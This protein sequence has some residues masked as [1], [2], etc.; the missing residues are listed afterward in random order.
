MAR[1]KSLL[2][3]YNY[4]CF[5]VKKY[6]L[7]FFDVLFNQY[8]NVALWENPHP[9]PTPNLLQLLFSEVH[10]WHIFNFPYW[11]IKW[12]PLV[13]RN[14]PEMLTCPYMVCLNDPC[15]LSCSIWTLRTPLA[16]VWLFVRWR[17]HHASLQTYGPKQCVTRQYV[18]IWASG[19]NS[20]C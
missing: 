19:Q 18:H 8:E 15:N 10:I 17:N 5:L 7:C 9:L 4:R 3:V 13:M 1:V 11:H 20:T 6:D 16:F 12:H 2:R 14:P